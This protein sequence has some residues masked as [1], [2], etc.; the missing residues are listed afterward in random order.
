MLLIVIYL[1][2]ASGLSVLAGGP[3]NHTVPSAL[4]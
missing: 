2:S 1:L 3:A 4:C